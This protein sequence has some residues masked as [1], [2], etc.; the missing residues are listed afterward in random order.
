MKSSFN[1][2]PDSVSRA[3]DRHSHIN[4][5]L[6]FRVQGK[7]EQCDALGW[8]DVGFN[9]YHAQELPP[10]TLEFKRSLTAFEGTI[11]WRSLNSP[12]HVVLEAL[13]NSLIFK[14]AKAVPNNAAL[15]RRLIKLMRVA[16]MVVPKRSVLAS[17]GLGISDAKLEQMV[18][19][20]R[21]ERPMY[22]YGVKV[23]SE[24]WRAIA[25]NAFAISSVVVSMEKMTDAFAKK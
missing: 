6:R 5:P 9:F 21:L 1:D 8:N 4:I 16:D 15:Q 13:L 17:M 19:Q 22:H 2:D 10:S 18:A 11:V 23:D 25:K 20:H 14:Q 3:E 12:N 24:A 7:W